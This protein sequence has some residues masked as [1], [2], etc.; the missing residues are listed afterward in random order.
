M[1]RKDIAE[2]LAEDFIVVAE[3]LVDFPYINPIHYCDRPLKQEYRKLLIKNYI[4]FYW[5]DEKTKKI[6]I[7]RVLYFKRDYEEL[8]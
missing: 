1:A 4:M 2:N 8:L 5:V 6:T 7:A 3:G